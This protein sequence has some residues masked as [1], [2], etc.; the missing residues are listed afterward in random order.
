M[1][2]GNALSE[3]EANTMPEETGAGTEPATGPVPVIVV[4]V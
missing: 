3:S 4:V 1:P 2:T